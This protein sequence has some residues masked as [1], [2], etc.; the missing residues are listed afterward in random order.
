MELL[1]CPSQLNGQL[2][3]SEKK[4]LNTSK[5]KTDKGEFNFLVMLLDNAVN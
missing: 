3:I 4:Y 2:D 5:T 1:V